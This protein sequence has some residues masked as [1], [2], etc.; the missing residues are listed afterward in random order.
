[1]D[2]V[3]VQCFCVNSFGVAVYQQMSIHRRLYS[4]KH[5]K[6]VLPITIL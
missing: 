1:M 6:Q 3:D 2:A 5:R 4:H